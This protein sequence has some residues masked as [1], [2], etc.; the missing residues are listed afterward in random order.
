MLEVEARQVQGRVHS[1]FRIVARMQPRDD[2]FHLFEIGAD[3]T[4]AVELMQAGE[5]RMLKDWTLSDSIRPGIGAT[6][7]LRVAYDGTRFSFYV[8]GALLAD[9]V[10]NTYAAGTIGLAAGTFKKGPGGRAL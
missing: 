5:W 7:Y 10:D 1:D 2:G 4:Y 9:L 8:N 6:N 3:G